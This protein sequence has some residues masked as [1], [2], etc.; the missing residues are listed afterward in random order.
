MR[1]ALPSA[2]NGKRLKGQ[3]VA[4]PRFGGD[5]IGQHSGEAKD[6]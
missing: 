6:D 5:K 2:L 4:K 3:R 1:V